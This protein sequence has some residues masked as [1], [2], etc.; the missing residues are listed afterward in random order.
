MS[1]S[2]DAARLGEGWMGHDKRLP[3]WLAGILCA[4]AT[5]AQAEVAYGIEMAADPALHGCVNDDQPPG[6]FIC[7]NVRFPDSR[8]AGYAVQAFPDTGICWIDAMSRP[9]DADLMGQSIRAT[10]DRFAAELALRYGRPQELVDSMQ[11]GVTVPED[12]LWLE[13]LIREEREYYHH[14]TSVPA[15]AQARGIREIYVSAAGR[16]DGSTVVHIEYFLANHDACV[17]N[18]SKAQAK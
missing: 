2:D 17:E 3:G 12:A 14:W 1:D 4:L 9:E 7:R 8:M 5:P 10:T 16:E 18:D 13:T 15:E 6:I 11:S